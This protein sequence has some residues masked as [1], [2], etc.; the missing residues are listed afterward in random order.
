[1]FPDD[2]KL[3]RPN[4]NLAKKVLGWSPNTSLQEGLNLTYSY[5]KNQLIKD[6]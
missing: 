2:P 3:R 6:E 4:I 5:F 1:M